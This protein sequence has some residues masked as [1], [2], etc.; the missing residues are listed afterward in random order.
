MVT[1]D[2]GSMDT[3]RREEQTIRMSRVHEFGTDLW[4][5]GLA[6]RNYYILVYL[7]GSPSRTRSVIMVP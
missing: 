7:I 3:E 6:S 1:N 2:P 5:E 4:H